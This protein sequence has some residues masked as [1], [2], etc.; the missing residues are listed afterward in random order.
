MKPLIPW[1]WVVTGLM[2][3]AGC[4]KQERPARPPGQSKLGNMHRSMATPR[5]LDK[6][7][8][9]GPNWPL[10]RSTRAAAC[11]AGRLNYLLKMT[12]PKPVKR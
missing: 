9:R 12:A 8:M 5:P 4:K 3:M 11:W 1:V 6:A 7:L 10:T 2:V